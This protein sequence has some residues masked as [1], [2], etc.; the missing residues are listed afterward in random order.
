[1]STGRASCL[2]C[3]SCAAG[4]VPF[5]LSPSHTHSHILKYA[6]A[7]LWSCLSLAKECYH[8]LS[9]RFKNDLSFTTQRPVRSFCIIFSCRLDSRSGLWSQFGQVSIIFGS[10]L[11]LQAEQQDLFSFWNACFLKLLMSTSKFLF[12]RNV[13][14]KDM[15][16][17]LRK[18]ATAKGFFQCFL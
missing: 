13:Q 15:S 12:W 11:L 7:V 3:D 4:N 16:I 6:Y 18:C 2:S 14:L 17:I 9:K 5:S 1:M 10:G 8:V